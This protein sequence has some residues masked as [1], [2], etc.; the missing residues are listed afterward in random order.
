MESFEVL[1]AG[2]G[3]AGGEL[4]RCLAQAGVSVCLVDRLADMRQA[5]FSSAALP[6][7]SVSRFGLPA[8]VLAASWH[9]WQLLGP[10]AIWH[11][12]QQQHAL[13]A[14]LDFGALRHW[15]T[16]QVQALGGEVRLA[17][18]VVAVETNSNSNQ[19]ITKLRDPHGKITKVKSNWVVDATGQSRCLIGETS[20]LVKDH[21]LLGIGLEW[22]LKV[23]MGR[24]QHWSKKL[25]FAL[26]SSWVPNGYGWVFPMQPGLLKVGVCRLPPPWQSKQQSGLALGLLQKQLLK[27]LDLGGATV[28]NRHGGV[29]RSRVQRSDCHGRGRLL[30]LGDAV[31]TAN[32]L[33]GEGI[34]HAM[35]SARVLLPLLLD[36]LA[37]P[38]DQKANQGLIKTYKKK[39]QGQLGTRWSL[40]G[41]LAKRTWWG[42]DNKAADQRMERL[43][44]GLNHCSA[45]DLSE[46]LFNYRFERFGLRALPYLFG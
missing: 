7:A 31:S 15:L 26:G 32:L 39:L 33:G 44:Q 46:L 41:R 8:E 17:S 16:V 30:A 18:S 22:L 45:A 36:A 28:I 4:A 9:G 19:L 2:A 12:W 40:S 37:I 10:N 24:W 13:G 23:D 43:L 34:R 38:G 1:V 6:L 29:I 27:E 35:E 20:N 21:L 5:A 14:V 42:L 11:Q 3:P 25:S